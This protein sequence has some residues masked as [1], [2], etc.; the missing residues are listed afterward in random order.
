MDKYMD[1]QSDERGEIKMKECPKCKTPIRSTTRYRSIVNKILMDIES[2]KD[3]VLTNKK[4]L[5]D[6]EDNIKQGLIEIN[7]ISLRVTLKQR[8]F[9]MQDPKAENALV[10]LLNQVT[11]AKHICSL[12]TEWKELTGVHFEGEQERGLRNLDNFMDWV[13]E[14][15]SFMTPQETSD[16]ER[17]IKRSRAHLTLLLIQ[18]KAVDKKI[19]FH[20]DLKRKIA[21]IESMLNGQQKYDDKMQDVVERCITTLKKI[22][23]MSAVG[24]SED[25]KVMIVQAMALPK[26]HWFKC[27]NG[28]V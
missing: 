5:H 17:E 6:L 12:K 16:A 13:V 15:R 20:A 19:Q 4:R 1:E 9:N 7:S 23:P 24:I 14:E 26:G 27:K 11:F 10:A 18:R 28:K 2:V 25:E 3:K 8:L 22:V 21:E